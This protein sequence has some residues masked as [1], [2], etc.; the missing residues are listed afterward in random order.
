MV[1]EE[2]TVSCMKGV[3]HKIWPSNENYGTNCDNLDMLIKETGKIAEVGPYNVDPVGITEILEIHSQPLSDE[4]LYDL[5][6]Q[7][8]EQQMEDED[9]E[10]RGTKEMQT[11]DF[12]DILCTMCMAAEKLCDI[13]PD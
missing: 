12:T 7:L 4:E 9:E 8:T 6:Q 2:V 13:D 5:A 1:W 3:W 10:D 11:T